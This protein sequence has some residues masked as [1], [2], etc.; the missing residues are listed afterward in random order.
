[1]RRPSLV[2]AAA[3]AARAPARLHASAFIMPKSVHGSPPSRKP[4]LQ[5]RRRP[6]IASL[7]ASV[8]SPDTGTNCLLL[9]S[10][11]D[12]VVGSAEGSAAFKSLLMGNLK[13]RVISDAFRESVLSSPCNGPDPDLLGRVLDS[14]SS[15]PP[16]DSVGPRRV[17]FVY[18][19][20]A[21]YAL[22]VGS[23]N[24]PGKQRQRARADGRSRRAKFENYIHNVVAAEMGG[25]FEV[26][27]VT[28]DFGD[29]SAKHCS[30][31]TAGG[32]IYKSVGNT[33]LDFPTDGA[34]ALRDWSPH[35][36]F[37]DGGNT[38]WLHHCMTGGGS[39]LASGTWSDALAAA[40]SGPEGAAYVGVSAGAIVA[41]ARADTATWKRWDD[42]RVVPGREEYRDWEG[43][44]GMGIAGDITVFPHMSEEW[45]DMIGEKAG[46]RD[47]VSLDE[48]AGLL[49]ESGLARS[50]GGWSWVGEHASQIEQFQVEKASID[51]FRDE[52]IP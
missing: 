1:M 35:L 36:V 24:T 44:A 30:R 12:G 43:Q 22:R 49:S 50:Y 4:G 42:P 18:I 25:N 34:S 51:P 47:V 11:T 16:P 40:C 21:R 8:E 38:F 28:V 46:A 7:C 31:T 52:G 10:F 14:T 41:G 19:P 5:Y 9:S 15:T 32:D 6:D 13:R 23:K 27:A 29:G 33:D 48:D 26:L 3:A 20:T 17:R 45:R 39:G 37:V 2:V